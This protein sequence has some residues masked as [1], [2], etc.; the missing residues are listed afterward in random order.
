MRLKIISVFVLMMGL[1][2]AT[3][4]SHSQDSMNCTPDALNPA[5]ETANTTLA[6]LQAELS[7]ATDPAQIRVLLN[8]IDAVINN[9]R[10]ACVL[11]PIAFGETVNNS[12]LPNQ[13]TV[14]T[15][16][17]N[18]GDIVSLSAI[19]TSGDADLAFELYAPDGNLL[20]RD[21]DSNPEGIFDPQLNN[22]PLPQ[23]GQYRI[24]M[25]RCNFCDVTN[26]ASYS[27]TLTQ[28]AAD[29]VA[30]TSKVKYGDD[31]TDLLFPNQTNEHFFDGTAGD[32]VTLTVFDEGGDVDFAMELYGPAGDLLF[33]D[34]DSNPE[35]IFD[36]QILNF[37]L[38]VDGAYRIVVTRCSFCDEAT[39]GS[40]RLTLALGG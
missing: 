2:S 27:L 33:E 25:T 4:V 26:T 40:Y 31:V 30:D 13:V 1:M 10:E 22:I 23:E 8:Q 6:D 24:V 29:S 12:L 7:N 28:E 32:V 16:I 21:D 18:I 39:S 20:F 36:P 17:A 15:F 11:F 3:F 19:T 34:D 35:G 5:L 9:I 37:T 38:P 14:H